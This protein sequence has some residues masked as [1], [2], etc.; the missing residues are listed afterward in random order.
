MRGADRRSTAQTYVRPCPL[1]NWAIR[2][3]SFA[4]GRYDAMTLA[5]LIALL[6]LITIK[7]AMDSREAATMRRPL[8]LI[9]LLEVKDAISLTI[10]IIGL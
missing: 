6:L 3:A 7:P 1:Q 10:E 2:K 4:E 9:L 8:K 5:E